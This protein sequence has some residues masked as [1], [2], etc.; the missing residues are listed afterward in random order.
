[1]AWRARVEEDAARAGRERTCCA[2]PEL[3]QES[4]ENGA[5]HARCNGSQQAVMSYTIP[6][7]KIGLQ[8]INEVGGKNAS[9]GELTQE[10]TP[11]G[12]AV[13]R[14]FALSARAFREHLIKAGLP[15][16]VYPALRALDPTNVAELAKLGSVIRAQISEAKLPR[17]V[18]QDLR[19]AY[20][21]LS[22]SYGEEETDVA[23]RSSA[24]AYALR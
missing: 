6:F 2:R 14:G 17:E 1:M 5:R 7:E 24:T 12:V 22:Q 8:D 20:R 19:R 15:E 23:V 18:E 11:H 16:H 9:L 10:L 4:P 21:E 3:H 13:P